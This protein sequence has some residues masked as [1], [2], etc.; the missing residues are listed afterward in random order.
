MRI[1]VI[2][3]HAFV[4][5]VLGISLV[6]EVKAD[7][8][9]F[10]IG[11]NPQPNEENILLNS[12]EIAPAGLSVYGLTN[13]TIALVR[14]NAATETIFEPANGQARIEASDGLINNIT[15]SMPNRNFRA[16]VLNPFF[17]GGNANVFVMTATNQTFDFNYALGNGE[18]FLTIITDANTSIFSVTINSPVGFTDLRQVRI[19]GVE[20]VPEPGTILLLGSGLLGLASAIRNRRRRK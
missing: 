18:N 1:S 13:R 15:I 11:N 6:A 2:A 4:L 12:G 14:F 7:S 10:L 19:A 20:G 3:R 8:V 16:I 5:F 9:T 17:G